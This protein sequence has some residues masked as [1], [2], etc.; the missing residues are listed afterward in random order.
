MFS[1]LIQGMSAELS[2]RNPP[3]RHRLRPPAGIAAGSPSG[4]FSVVV[5]LS[6]H[7]PPHPHPLHLL[8]GFCFHTA[9]RFAEIIL[10]QK[11]ILNPPLH[12]VMQAFQLWVLFQLYTRSGAPWIYTSKLYFSFIIHRFN[13]TNVQMRKIFF[14]CHWF[15]V[16]P[17]FLHSPRLRSRLW[18]VLHAR[19]ISK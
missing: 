12:L 5:S 19:K 18:S 3:F 16:Y 10:T 9:K 2:G 14:V 7:T 13:D 1:F 15:R 4:A 8:D 11:F 17:L 6:Q